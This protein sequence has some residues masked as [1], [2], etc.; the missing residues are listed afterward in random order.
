MDES[1]SEQEVHEI[2]GYT[3]TER[4]TEALVIVEIDLIAGKT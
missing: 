3:H 4:K 1:S 2:A